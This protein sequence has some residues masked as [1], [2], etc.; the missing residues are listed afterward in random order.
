[1]IVMIAFW[2]LSFQTDDGLSFYDL[3]KRKGTFSTVCETSEIIIYLFM[4]LFVHLFKSCWHAGKLLQQKLSR[5]TGIWKIMQLWFTDL[6][7]CSRLRAAL[8]FIKNV[9]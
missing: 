8:L 1:M 5:P 7:S 3:N 4:Y 9:I 6:M 2:C